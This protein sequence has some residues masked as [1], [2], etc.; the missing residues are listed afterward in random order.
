[1]NLIE[2]KL[3]FDFAL[4]YK[5]V[6]PLYLNFPTKP[7]SDEKAMQGNYRLRLLIQQTKRVAR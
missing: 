4:N 6:P 5:F 7:Q 3:D 2:E 1:M